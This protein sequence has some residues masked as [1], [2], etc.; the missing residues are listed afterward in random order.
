MYT[1]SLISLFKTKP[2]KI[3]SSAIGAKT[4]V[5]NIFMIAGNNECFQI[6]I[7]KSPNLFKENSVNKIKTKSPNEVIA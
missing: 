5:P 3:N 1:F 4:I 7:S 6:S 2:L